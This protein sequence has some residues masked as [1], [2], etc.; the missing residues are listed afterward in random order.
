LFIDD[1]DNLLE[2]NSNV[3]YLLKKVFSENIISSI[4]GMKLCKGNESAV[5]D[6][7][8]SYSSVMQAYIDEN[9]NRFFTLEVCDKLPEVI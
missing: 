6:V 5:F 7:A 2:T 8:E 1:E 3:F 9:D 4:R